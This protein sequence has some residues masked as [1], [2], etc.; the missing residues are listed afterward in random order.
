[1]ETP[2]VVS[3]L[4]LSSNHSKLN[5]SEWFDVVHLFLLSIIP[6]IPLSEPPKSLSK[7]CTRF[8]PEVLLERC[9][10]CISHWDIA[11]LHRNEFFVGLEI[12]VGRQD[13]CTDKFLL[14][15]RHEIQKILRG[16]VADVVHLVWRNRKSVLAVLL[17][18]GM[19]HDTDHTLHDVIDIGEVAFAVAVVEDLDGLAFSEFV[20]EAE[21]RHVGTAGW[22]ID[23]KETETCGRDIV[24]LRIGMGHELVA[25][26][27]RSVEAHRIVH[28]VICRIRHL[29]VASV[30]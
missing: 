1:M 20:G 19:S 23:R 26:L 3:E 12:V 2:D 30:N 28:L 16:V 15:N 25:L 21:I 9:G 8:E 10:I 24:E 4:P 5:G 18:R 7:R 6:S 22:A 13:S 14:E 11:G 17:L 27:G 29:L